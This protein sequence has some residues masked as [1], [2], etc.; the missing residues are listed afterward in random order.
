MKKRI[1]VDLI[2]HIVRM[3]L[4]L[5]GTLFLLFACNGQ[6]KASTEKEILA[7]D[8]GLE[9]L[10]IDN[11]SGAEF[12]ETLVI[13]DVIALE[14]FYSQINRTRKPGLPVPE[15]DFNKEI[16]VITCSGERN[17]GLV[18]IIRLKEE[19]SSQVILF[20]ELKTQENNTS[21]AITS[22]FSIYKMPLTDK[23]VIFA[24]AKQ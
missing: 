17:D 4:F 11:H 6:K 1:I 5:L 15:I 24:E 10:I 12:S 7:M 14:S 22:P 23:E 2:K 16:L 19:T 3:K 18:P 8:A 21:P 9:L 13:K 20:T